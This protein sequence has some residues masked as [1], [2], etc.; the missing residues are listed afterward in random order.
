MPI[1]VGKSILG[2]G[3][4]VATGNSVQFYNAH[5]EYSLPRIQ[6]VHR[7]AAVRGETFI[8]KVEGYISLKEDTDRVSM[9]VRVT[10]I[11]VTMS[12]WQIL[13][14]FLTV[15]WEPGFL[16]VEIPPQADTVNYT[17]SLVQRGGEMQLGSTIG[18]K[19]TPLP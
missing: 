7:V 19:V 6:G 12:G 3:R 1:T 13:S 4:Q 15:R 9:D 16:H 14:P 17:L 18:R 2:V 10:R 5:V 8:L 11:G